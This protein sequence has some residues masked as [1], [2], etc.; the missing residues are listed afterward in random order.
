[1]NL[2]F[3]AVA[4][5][6][7]AVTN[8]DSLV[9]LGMFFATA[10]NRRQS[11]RRVIIGQYLG[12]GLILVAS[13]AV[14]FSA[15]AVNAAAV[16]PYLGVVPL[17]IGLRSALALIRERAAAPFA[18]QPQVGVIGVATTCV[19]T[20]G[21]NI[22]MYAPA[23][24]TGGVT[25]IADYSALFLLGVA[26]WCV[27]GWALASRPL[28]ARLLSNWNAQIMPAVMIGLGC[29]ILIRGGVLAA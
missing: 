8:I 11:I 16:L 12:F 17:A 26:V 27:L 24:S 2:G 10:G 1:M 3:V 7:F 21:D 28:V 19:S 29:M 25:G 9:M 14:A 15:I 13:C 18:T 23:F 6:M 5:P 4:A 22:A 20:G